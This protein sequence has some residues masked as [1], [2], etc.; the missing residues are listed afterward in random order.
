MESQECSG[1][2]ASFSVHQ[3]QPSQDHPHTKRMNDPNEILMESASLLEPSQWYSGSVL[4]SR[5]KA[6]TVG[7]SAPKCNHRFKSLR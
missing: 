6:P 3:I 4:V 5:T 7:L 2:E 1:W